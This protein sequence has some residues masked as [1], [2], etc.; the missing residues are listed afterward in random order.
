MQ[1][2]APAFK[3]LLII[4]L[5]ILIQSPKD[6]QFKI[7]LIILI[8]IILIQYPRQRNCTRNLRSPSTSGS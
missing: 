7:R 1:I 8:L 4:I 5:T 2:I 6:P 3:I